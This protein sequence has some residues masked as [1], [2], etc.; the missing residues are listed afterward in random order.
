MAVDLLQESADLLRLPADHY[1]VRQLAT[2][3]YLH[4]QLLKKLTEGDTSVLGQLTALAAS[5]EEMAPPLPPQRVQFEIAVAGYTCTE[6]G[7]VQHDLVEVVTKTDSGHLP[8][9]ADMH[10]RLNGA[11]PNSHPM[12][13]AGANVAEQPSQENPPRAVS[14]ALDAYGHELSPA[15]AFDRAQR[16]AE[17]AAEEARQRA[18]AERIK[19]TAAEGYSNNGSAVWSGSKVAKG[20]RYE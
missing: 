15:A 10:R 7:H 13:G 17:I 8:L 5:I 11:T 1:R 3:R 14:V 6:C 19:P 2:T 9:T 16:R 20:P 12:A 4:E 18:E